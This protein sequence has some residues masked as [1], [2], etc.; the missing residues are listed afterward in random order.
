MAITSDVTIN[1][2]TA[3]D[4]RAEITI[5][6]NKASG[7]FLRTGAATDVNLQSL[8]LTNFFVAG[9]GGAVRTSGGTLNISD[10]T[11]QR[12]APLQGAG[13]YLIDTATTVTNSLI[14]SNTATSDSF[15]G[16]GIYAF[17]GAL[18]LN[19]VTV[20]GNTSNSFGSG[21]AVTGT[22]LELNNSTVAFN[23]ADDN[24]NFPTPGG[25]LYLSSGST[26]TITNSLEQPG[27]EQLCRQRH[28]VQ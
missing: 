7:I 14:L 12:S 15:G 21:M 6:G 17:G 9:F 28:G 1:G 23:T 26:S 25:G 27:R 3:G 24:V 20:T 5:S 4:A 13:F 16:S 2:D 8:T 19:Q 11:I 22:E 10:T 18:P